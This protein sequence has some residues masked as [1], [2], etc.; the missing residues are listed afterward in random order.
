MNAND[1]LLLFHKNWEM[2]L[3]IIKYLCI[4][5]CTYKDALYICEQFTDMFLINLDSQC[6]QGLLRLMKKKVILK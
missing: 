6:F 1:G 4:H 2:V 5:I 3:G